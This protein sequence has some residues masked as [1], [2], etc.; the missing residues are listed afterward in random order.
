MG[1]YQRE[2]VYLAFQSYAPGILGRI[3]GW[4]NEECQILVALCNRELRDPKLHL[5]TVFNFVYGRKPTS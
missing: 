2:H 4:S 3:L 5:Y 1:L